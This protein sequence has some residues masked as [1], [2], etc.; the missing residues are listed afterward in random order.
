MTDS[1][2]AETPKPGRKKQQVQAVLMIHGIGE[3]IPMKTLRSFVDTVWT[4]DPSQT[5]DDKER[6]LFSGPDR[7]SGS[8]ELR[9]LISSRNS[10]H[11]RTDFF[12]F[13]WAHTVSDTR[14]WHVIKWIGRLFVRPPER[15]TK[16]VMFAWQAARVITA[17][18][19]ILTI[20]L[21]Y[22][23]ATAEN[24]FLDSFKWI[25][26]FAPMAFGGMV[27]SI[28]LRT[29]GDAARYLLPEP[30]NI[31]N[32][33]EIRSAGVK[34]LRALTEMKNDD[35]QYKYDR[36]IIVG[37]SLGA[38]IGYDIL[39]GAWPHYNLCREMPPKG[40]TNAMEAVEVAGKAEPFN[41]ADYRNKQK[42]FGAELRQNGNPW[43]ITD[44]V[45]LGSPLAHSAW[46]MAESADDFDQKTEQREFPICPPYAD[47]NKEQDRFS[48]EVTRKK[49]G[50]S[51]GSKVFIPDHAAVFG[52][53]RWTNVYFPSSFAAHGDLIGGPAAPLYGKG[54]LDIEA[55]HPKRNAGF[56][57]H[58][59]YWTPDSAADASN[60]HLVT[61]RKAINLLDEDDP[62]ALAKKKPT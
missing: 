58:V 61:L 16:S 36:I 53:V 6:D 27:N 12:E 38:V 18:V 21:A 54:V 26:M 52:A 1:K 2:N 42:A 56:F 60:A 47:G 48:Y 24:P 19:A 25:V 28:L 41:L 10:K 11:V 45:T 17:I 35:G 3:Q 15:T 57:S 30:Y 59:F 44:F 32:R 43:A 55:T 7:V 50:A 40:P 20:G 8:F 39:R 9:R 14:F 62:F 4:E 33:H 49:P 31:K 29:V 13:Y 34:I 37:H 23:Y 51:R 5:A 22:Y 46:L